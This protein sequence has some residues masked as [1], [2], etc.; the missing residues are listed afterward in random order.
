MLWKRQ[1]LSAGSVDRQ[2]AGRKSP[3]PELCSKLTCSQYRSPYGQRLLWRGL[4]GPAHQYTTRSKIHCTHTHTGLGSHTPL[5]PHAHTAHEHLRHTHTELQHSPTDVV[6]VLCSRSL[7]EMW[8]KWHSKS[9]MSSEPCCLI[10]RKIWFWH[11]IFDHTVHEK[12]CCGKWWGKE[13]TSS[14]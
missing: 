6:L 2:W 1:A 13:A 4:H 5:W 11:A 12:Q 7:Q 10:W 8:K 14:K 9:K 3:S